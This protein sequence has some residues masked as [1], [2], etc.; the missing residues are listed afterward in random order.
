MFQ[1]AIFIFFISLFLLGCNNSKQTKKIVSESTGRLT[2][3]LIVCEQQDWDGKIG[4]ELRTVFSSSL[5]GLPNPEPI[6]TVN[7]LP[8][9]VFSGFTKKNRL[10]IKINPSDSTY[11]KINKNA[12]ARPQ[13]LVELYG[14][15]KEDVISLIQRSKND[16]I[17]TFIKQEIKT[18]Q[19]QI[20]QSLF[21]DSI[22][23]EKFG[24][25]MQLPTSYRLAKSSEDFVWLRSDLRTG[26]KDIVVY[27]VGK[28]DNENSIDYWVNKR[29][30]IGQIHIPGPV[31]GSFMG[32][33][34]RYDAKTITTRI[35]GLEAKEIRGLWDMKNDVM[36]GPYLMYV[37][38]DKKN[39]RYLVAEGYLYAPS[40]DKREYML[41]L[42]AILK[43]IKFKA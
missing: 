41:E 6:F 32:T 13:V 28:K 29:D 38:E 30:S 19:S 15:T 20:R 9:S 23:F 37:I 42:E 2:H 5:D 25:S 1:K 21:D 12:F 14:E 18:R 3:L 43:S 36:S 34:E 40:L 24:I 4:K 33:E 26:T 17:E 35:A 39:K 7:H 8:T 11:I 10:V 22:L 31:K 27:T 16:I